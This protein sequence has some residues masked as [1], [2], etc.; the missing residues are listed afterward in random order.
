M[1]SKSHAALYTRASRPIASKTSADADNASEDMACLCRPSPRITLA[2]EALVVLEGN[3]GRRL[4]TRPLLI[5]EQSHGRIWVCVLMVSK[6]SYRELNSPVLYGGMASGMPTLPT[7]Q[8]DARP[9]HL[10]VRGPSMCTFT[11]EAASSIPPRRLDVVARSL[12]RAS[13]ISPPA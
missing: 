13:T 12:E 1:R 9:Q 5:F 10:G 2:V 6:D 8:G 4:R 11:C 3:R 7:Y